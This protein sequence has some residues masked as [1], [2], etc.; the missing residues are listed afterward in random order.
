MVNNRQQATADVDNNELVQAADAALILQYVVGL[1]TDFP[2]STAGKEDGDSGALTWGD[3]VRHGH[4]EWLVP[5]EID[6]GTQPINAIE[7]SVTFSISLN[8]PDF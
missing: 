6:P 3:P 2:G 1:I 4:G 5:L 7:T 8:K